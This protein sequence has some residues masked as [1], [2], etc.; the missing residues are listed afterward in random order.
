VRNRTWPVVL[1]G[2]GCLLGLIAWPGWIMLQGMQR[3]FAETARLQERLAVRQQAIQAM[4]E[5][6]PYSSIVLRDHLLDSAPTSGPRYEQQFTTNRREI[7]RLLLG[8]RK[9]MPGDGAGPLERLDQYLNLHYA[10]AAPS[11]PGPPR[12]NTSEALTFSARSR[13]HAAMTSSPSPARSPASAPPPTNA[14]RNRSTG[15][16]RP[17]ATKPEL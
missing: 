10:S 3:L 9:S 8:L 15:N 6:I 14:R 7:N 17:F 2:L 16:N 4:N 1:F 13:V 5:R 11:S 12:I